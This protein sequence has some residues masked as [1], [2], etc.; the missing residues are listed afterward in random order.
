MD[1]P[2]TAHEPDAESHFASLVKFDIVA[3]TQLSRTLSRPDR[4][5]L[6]RAF[7][8]AVTRAIDGQDVKVEW[9]GDGGLIA[10]GYPGVRYDPA[11]AAVTTALQLV[12][13]VQGL[14]A[15]P[16]VRLQLCV[17][18]ASGPVTVD[19]TSGGFEGLE[20]ISRAD[21]LM[22]CGRPGQ[23]LIAADTKRLVRGY[24]EYEDLGE[25]DL[26][27]F[28]PTHVWR[29]VR[30]SGIVSRFAARLDETRRTI[31]G[32][33]H[34]LARLSAAW[35]R[36][37]EGHGTAICLT[38]DAGIGK[39]RL[40][41]ALI[42]R[43]REA[44]AVVLE[45]DCGPSTG[46]SPLFPIGVLLQRV[47]GIA[48]QSTASERAESA[49]RLLSSLLGDDQ[50]A[51]MFPYV[52]TVFGIEGSP[53]TRELTR[54]Q[55]RTATIQGIV[56][57]VQALAA[58]SR[59][60]EGTAPSR[61]LLLL[62]EDLHW[63]D[64][65][66]A[67]VVQS[68]ALAIASV[69]A[70]MVVTRWP[71]PVTPI[72][73]DDIV[74]N[75]ETIPVEPLGDAAAGALVRMVAG[76]L[77]GNDQV[78]AIVRRCGGVPLLLE[79][80]TR[81]TLEEDDA[82]TA[83]SGRPGS[84]VPPE[85]QLVVESRLQRWIGLKGIIEAAAVL[86]RDFPV[87]A[88]AAMMPE[89]HEDIAAAV[90]RFATEGLFAR[91]ESVGKGRAAFRHGLIRDA[92]YETLVSKEYLRRLHSRAA[93]SLLTQCAGTPDA[94]P[95]VVA[96]HLLLAG[97]LEEALRLRLAAAQS[98]FEH[99]AYVEAAGHCEAARDL[100][101][102]LG[103][104]GTFTTDACRL[105]ALRGM[106]FS[107]RHGYSTEPAVAAYREAHSMLEPTTPA[108]LRYPVVRGLG[109]AS[110]VRGD[111]AD[112]YGYSLEGVAVANASNRGDY[113]LDAL[114]I[115]SYTTMYCGR[116]AE[117]RDHI[118]QFLALY[119]AEHGEQFRYPVPHDARTAVLG[120]L[121]T[122]A[123]LLGDPRGAERAIQQ[124]IDHVE[125]LG[126]DFDR[127][128]LHSW[129]AG[130]RYTQRRYIDALRHAGLA[131]EISKRHNFEEWEAVS[132][133]LALLSQCAL[134]PAPA[135][136]A[137]A[138]DIAE[139]FKSRG[140]GLNASYYLWGIARGLVV[141]GDRPQALQVLESALAVAAASEETR[142]NAEIW[143]LQAEI[144]ESESIAVRLLLDAYRLSQDQGAVANAVRA[145]N[146]LLLRF[147][148]DPIQSAQ[149]Q[150]LL[151]MLDGRV[152]SDGVPA[153]WMHDAMSAAAT[154][155]SF[156]E[157][158]LAAL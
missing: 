96:Q 5:E 133:M 102:Q 142:M 52:A 108:E 76:E 6:L 113:R 141:A 75:M 90:T 66:T 23:V 54:D 49:R 97:R 155:M 117:S 40:A 9:E 43:A 148:T 36:A 22:R 150:A 114:S 19:L 89:R 144:T 51:E 140:V 56:R 105:S 98:T 17:G 72:P 29:V 57:I 127:A 41:R 130:V 92:V 20:Q 134:A 46:N 112:A 42:D 30:P 138:I 62:A 21:R 79:E 53:L 13:G 110:L 12:E 128:M 132:G 82:G 81:N 95:D 86:G 115:L 116:L 61:P 83:R 131:Y 11:H 120:I 85:L 149:A 121:P 145:A 125:R 74:S 45:I 109:A 143:M 4:L 37:G 147:A 94:A 88:L 31:V 33:E 107:A 126:R 18:V 39:S 101:R 146:L 14:T 55:A 2:A 50:A 78:D 73:L 24:F 68:V 64:D 48:P 111:L 151:D 44:N 129:I 10:F 27:P 91:P 123:W 15:I 28:G 136:L 16:E 103:N 119:D 65:T 3:S 67:Q 84:V 77:V 80:V 122:V 69:P 152:P 32:R 118:E 99:G 58:P 71:T 63:A 87:P 26:R 137:Q 60:S 139:L 106:V 135:Q 1:Q 158:K 70:M 93:D 25:A 34:I 59:S 153:T 35:E 38:G 104:V 8:A 157:V 124:G 7:R 156:V 47:A 154:A 100:L